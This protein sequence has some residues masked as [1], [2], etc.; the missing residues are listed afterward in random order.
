MIII[1]I[2][3][4][5][6]GNAVEKTVRGIIP[7]SACWSSWH[8]TKPHSEEPLSAF[9]L[10]TLQIW[11]RSVHSVHSVSTTG[12]LDCVHRLV[13]QT[14]VSKFLS[15]PCTTSHPKRTYRNT[16]SV[17]SSHCTH[18]SQ[19]V[20]LAGCLVEQE[21][22]RTLVTDVAKFMPEHTLPHLRRRQ[23]S[24]FKS[25]ESQSSDF[26]TSCISLKNSPCMSPKLKYHS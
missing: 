12:F 8:L 11:S 7:R 21:W 3:N 25:C 26:I 17:R 10:A 5:E 16:A 4:S 24:Q 15:T 9:K 18:P 19:P 22:G 13:L 23:S 14:E 20:D 6:F 2:I 1:I